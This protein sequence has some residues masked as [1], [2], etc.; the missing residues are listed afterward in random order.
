VGDLQ[1]L[2]RAARW[3]D[4][5]IESTMRTLSVKELNLDAVDREGT[6]RS[7]QSQTPTL[8]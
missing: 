5:Y 2:V 7:T 4:L 6:A 3:T 1:S 8:S